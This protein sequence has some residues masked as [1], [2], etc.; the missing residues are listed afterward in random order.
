MVVDPRFYEK[1]S[2]R[3]GDPYDRLGQA[4]ASSDKRK[5]EREETMHNL[6]MASRMPRQWRMMFLEP[7]VA[8]GIVI[9]VVILALVAMF[10]PSNG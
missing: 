9:V 4:L 10:K 6:K 7:K 2:G 8:I 5:H 1:H 3:K